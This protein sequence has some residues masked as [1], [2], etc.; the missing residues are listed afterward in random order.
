MLH[1]AT[2]T[3]WRPPLSKTYS[4]R[5]ARAAVRPECQAT[6][7]TDSIFRSECHRVDSEDGYARCRVACLNHSFCKLLPLSQAYRYSTYK[8]R[9]LWQGRAARLE[10]AHHRDGPKRKGFEKSY[11]ICCVLF[12]E[13]G[14]ET[15]QSD[16]IQLSTR[17]NTKGWTWSRRQ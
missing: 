1:Q 17:P 9:T 10:S 16:S 4:G 15:T 12:L 2:P 7:T 8:F 6:S 5:S 11:F 14:C 3:T 13:N